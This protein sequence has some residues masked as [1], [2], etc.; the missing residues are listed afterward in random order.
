MPSKKRS[1]SVPGLVALIF[2]AVL[3][4]SS[5]G[6]ARASLRPAA[7]RHAMTIKIGWAGP[8]SGD[9]AYFGQSWLNG[10]K[11]A[12]Q[13]F[14]FSGK[15][16]GAMVRVI[17]LDDA[18]DPAQGV[19]VA[20]RLVAQGVDG[21][22]ADFN[23]GV[24]LA[25]E[26][27]YHAADIP[28]ITNSSNP[29]I[30]ARGYDNIVQLIA[31]DN[32][33]GGFMATFARKTLHVKSVAVFNDSAAFGQGVSST[34]AAAAAKG[35]VTVVGGNTALSPTSQDYTGALS[36]VLAKHPDAIYFGGVATGGGLLCRQARAAGFK[37]PFMGPDGLF[38][39]AFIK[40]CG[41][42]I[43]TAYVSFQAPPYTASQTLREF[44]QTYKVKF[45]SLAGPYSVYGYN[46]M[47]F[48]LTAINAAGTTSHMAVIG[49]LHR[50]TYNS[51][52]GTLYINASGQLQ[53]APIYVY[54]VA[55]STFKLVMGG[56]G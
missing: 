49:K 46:E 2:C 26:P 16:A 32:I 5:G 42:S 14:K 33:Q 51:I 43:G 24:T 28:Q 39:P 37:G 44:A 40:G 17:P 53:H 21:V 56:R 11:L 27:I 22:I 36:P 31:N 18:A 9:Q 35:G 47:G 7:A 25:S 10:V 15:L 8:L 34:F 38:D 29:R 3:V 54:K 19:T 52:L 20:H 13:T 4:A 1:L 55:G 12:A 6:V 41:P 30:T 45:G 50:I 48:L 23:S